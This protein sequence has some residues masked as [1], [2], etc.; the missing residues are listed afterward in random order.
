[1]TRDERMLE[2]NFDRIGQQVPLPADPSDLQ[3]ARWTE[4]GSGG[5]AR[6]RNR[7]MLRKLFMTGGFGIAAAAALV[8][9][10]LANTPRVASA[11]QIF[12]EARSAIE[13]LRLARIEFRDVVWNQYRLNLVAH[14]S[15]TESGEVE[16]ARI[17]T[18]NENVPFGYDEPDFSIQ[19]DMEGSDHEHTFVSSPSG[20]WSYLKLTRLADDFEERN[21]DA[22]LLAPLVESARSG[23]YV[24][25]TRRL[26]AKAVWFTANLNVLGLADRDKFS[27]LVQAVEK[28]AEAI[29]VERLDG[30]RMLLRASNYQGRT[31]EVFQLFTWQ[32]RQDDLIDALFSKAV[33]EVTSGD[34]GIERIRITNVAH[35][36][37]IEV[38]FDDRVL[39]FD[40]SRLS[41]SAE[42]KRVAGAVISADE[43][44]KLKPGGRKE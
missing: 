12:A 10:V 19:W 25:R 21:P 41:M 4:G 30:G 3:V 42:K 11:A 38:S 26:G 35:G 32:G 27:K 37:E 7:T 5:V 28:R 31:G 24:D 17:Q 22:K 18:R 2:R 9:T 34:N 44:R 20:A 43:L 40:P 23:V 33:F 14:V 36:G 29:E 16:S 39:D 8:F 6:R 13:R 1:M 15:M